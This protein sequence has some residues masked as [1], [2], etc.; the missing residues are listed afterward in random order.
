MG[1]YRKKPVVIEAVQWKG[2][3]D[4]ARDLLVQELNVPGRYI[5]LGD[6][7]GQLKITTLEGVMIA[8]QSD[9]IIKGVHG[10]VY[11]CKKD[12]FQKTYEP[13][14]KKSLWDRLLRR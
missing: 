3:Y 13:V 1:F 10:E 6:G 12:I 14:K 11:P 2:G 7:M 9:W 8:D 5:T 4:T